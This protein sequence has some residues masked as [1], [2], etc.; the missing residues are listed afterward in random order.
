MSKYN[1]VMADRNLF[2][3]F[4]FSCHPEINLKEIKEEAYTIRKIFPSQNMSNNNGYHSPSFIERSNY[5]NF[6]LLKEITEEFSMGVVNDLNLDLSLPKVSWWMNINKECQYNI[7]HTHARADL[8]GVYY[9]SAPENSGNL[10]LLR[11][12]G[13]SYSHLYQNA[14]AGNL[15]FTIPAE[16][17]R[18]YIIPGHLWHYVRTSESQEDR[19]SVSF[20]IHFD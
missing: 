10:V 16:I 1:N 19:I 17:G 20:N 15:S 11:N 13:S 6:D 12:D 4:I 5:K 3:S 14:N 2:S 8:I 9:I 7:L 18:L